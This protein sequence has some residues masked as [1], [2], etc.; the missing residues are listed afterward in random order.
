MRVVFRKLITIF[1]VIWLGFFANLLDIF[2]DFLLR[3]VLFF[4]THIE[5]LFN[6]DD[7]LI[8]G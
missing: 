8:N 6:I 2:A 4:L 5:L 1:L 7:V 3:L